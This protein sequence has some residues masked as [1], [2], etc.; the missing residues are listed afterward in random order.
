MSSIMKHDMNISRDA[1]NAHDDDIR[2]LAIQPLYR[3]KVKLSVSKNVL[4]R[5]SAPVHV[6]I[7]SPSHTWDLVLPRWNSWFTGW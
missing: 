1:T 6:L 5:D 7:D 3:I 2:Q 4:F